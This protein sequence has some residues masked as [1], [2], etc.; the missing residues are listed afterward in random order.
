MLSSVPESGGGGR[1]QL[2][3]VLCGLGHN[4]LLQLHDN[5]AQWCAL[6]IAA[7]LD[8]KVDQRVG[9]S[10][11]QSCLISESIAWLVKVKALHWQQHR[12]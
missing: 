8:V 12:E 7:Q 11:T 4:V 9:L 5:A 3:E 1:A 6:A 10:S 2:Q